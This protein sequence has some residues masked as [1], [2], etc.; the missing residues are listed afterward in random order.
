MP[1]LLKDLLTGKD[2]E[3]YD[4]GR[5]LWFLC[6][7]AFIGQSIYALVISADHHFDPQAYGLGAGGILAGGGGGIGFKAKTEPDA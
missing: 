1:P 7:L 4:V 3:S 6:M 5:V 2:G